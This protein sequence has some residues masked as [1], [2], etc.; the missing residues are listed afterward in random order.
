MESIQPS[1]ISWSIWEKTQIIRP[2]MSKQIKISI[3]LITSNNLHC[4]LMTIIG[5]RE[6]EPKIINSFT[7]IR[8]LLSRTRK[9]NLFIKGPDSKIMLN[10]FLTLSEKFAWWCPTCKT[11]ND[12]RISIK[13]SRGMVQTYSLSST[14]LTTRSNFLIDE[15]NLSIFLNKL[16]LA[17]F[18]FFC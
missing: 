12:I 17:L 14:G 7:I 3:W 16:F 8:L 11:T 9:G 15:P 5:L 18:H 6:P 2:R 4:F 13:I 1:P 10:C